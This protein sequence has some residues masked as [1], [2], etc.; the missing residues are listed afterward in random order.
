M[1]AVGKMRMGNFIPQNTFCRWQC[2]QSHEVVCDADKSAIRRNEAMKDAKE[3]GFDEEDYE[4]LEEELESE[5]EL[6]TNFVDTCG[7]ILKMHKSNFL[8]C[9]M[10]THCAGLHSLLQHIIL[11]PFATMRFAFLLM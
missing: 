7:Y 8:P 4:N 3:K 2:L 10:H 1:K 6:M 11:L 5:E 9:S